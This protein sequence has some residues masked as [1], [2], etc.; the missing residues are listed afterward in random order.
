MK[1]VFVK[2]PV[3]VDGAVFMPGDHEVDTETVAALEAAGALGDAPEE[4]G[5]AAPAAMTAEDIDRLVAERARIIAETIVGAAVEQAVT[6]LADERDAALAR[7]VSAEARLAEIEAA[8]KARAE[9]IPATTTAPA[10]K[11]PKKGVAAPK[12]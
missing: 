11:A 3:K 7:A 9:D 4:P 10:A 1:K 8:T 5:A 2:N 12:G 6:S